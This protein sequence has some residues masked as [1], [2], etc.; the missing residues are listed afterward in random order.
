MR[1]GEEHAEN[2]PVSLHQLLMRMPLDCAAVIGATTRLKP[3]A[4]QCPPPPRCTHT[5]IPLII[6]TVLPGAR[7][8][9]IILSSHHPSLAFIISPHYVRSCNMTGTT[10]F[11]STLCVAPPQL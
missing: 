4:T 1:E 9:P 7:I 5:L 2:L 3:D 6:P 11:P 8:T 10:V